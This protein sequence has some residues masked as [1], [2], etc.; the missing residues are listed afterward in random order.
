MHAENAT[1]RA[2][3][4]PCGRESRRALERA[5]R[6]IRDAIVLRVQLGVPLGSRPI[7]IKT[8]EDTYGGELPRDAKAKLMHA[9]AKV[10]G[11]RFGYTFVSRSSQENAARKHGPR[12]KRGGKK[13]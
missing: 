1:V 2:L 12:G 7:F 11:P 9:H 8:L 6:C 4:M 10:I 5:E 3:S 13:L